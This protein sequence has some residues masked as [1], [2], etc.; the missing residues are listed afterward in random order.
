MATSHGFDLI[1]L[2]SMLPDSNG[3]NVC[4]EIR[5]TGI[6]TPILVL[7]A[8]SQMTDMLLGFK[9]GADGYVM[10]P[11]ETA[12]LLARIEAQLRRAGVSSPPSSDR[13]SAIKF[14]VRHTRVTRDGRPVYMT[15]H[16]FRLLH[17][18]AKRSGRCVTRGELLNAVWG[19]ASNSATRTIDMHIASLR[20]KLELNPKIPELIL[21]IPKLGYMFVGSSGSYHRR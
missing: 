3:L 14:D 1:L 16:E 10:K 20:K 2:D 19:Y 7:T 15:A 11:F 21:T 17:Y 8:R 12:E 6:A 18:L 5:Q 9:L 13:V 4:R